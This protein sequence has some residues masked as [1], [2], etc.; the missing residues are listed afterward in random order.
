[1]PTAVWCR[2]WAS[3]TAG[4][5]DIGD[6]SGSFRIAITMGAVDGQVAGLSVSN[7]VSNALTGWIRWP[8][9]E[10][11]SVDRPNCPRSVFYRALTLT[12]SVT[13]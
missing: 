4:R 12:L 13:L 2:D 5:R 9:N 6:V 7:A 8:N 10:E 3:G 1:M 11:Y